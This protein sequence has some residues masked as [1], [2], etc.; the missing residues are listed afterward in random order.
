M[1]H[2]DRKPV[3]VQGVPRRW[4]ERAATAP[5]LSAPDRPR[6]NDRCGSDSEASAP[7]PRAFAAAASSV[8]CPRNRAARFTMS[9]TQT[10]QPGGTALIPNS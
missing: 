8:H 10:S 5:S 2:A 9:R 1:A 4:V 6:S 7:A 3:E